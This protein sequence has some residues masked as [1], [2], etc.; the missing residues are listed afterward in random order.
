LALFRLATSGDVA[1]LAVALPIYRDL[2]SLLRWDS[3]TEF[4]QA[5][6]LSMDVAGRKGGACRPPR[7]A[8]TASTAAAIRGA[9][10]AALAKGYR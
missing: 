4:V 9:T 10:E 1:D 5:I 8:L 7:G 2:H 6:K 3:R